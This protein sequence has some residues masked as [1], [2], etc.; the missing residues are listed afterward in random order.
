MQLQ[1]FN[2]QVLFNILLI[3]SEATHTWLVNLQVQSVIQLTK[4]IVA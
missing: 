4:H 3:G 1:Q 2:L